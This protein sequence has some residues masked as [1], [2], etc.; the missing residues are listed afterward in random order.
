MRVLTCFADADT[1]VVVC[2]AGNKDRYESRTGGDWY[3]DYVPVADPYRS[4][5]ERDDDYHR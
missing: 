3:G 1:T 2:L 4:K 5:R